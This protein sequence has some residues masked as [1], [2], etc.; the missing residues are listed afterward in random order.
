M[1]VSNK[2]SILEIDWKGIYL[3]CHF[4]KEVWDLE[5]IW[6]FSDSVYRASWRIPLKSELQQYANNYMKRKMLQSQK[7]I[8]ELIAIVLAHSSKISVQYLEGKSTQEREWST[9]KNKYIKHEIYCCI[10]YPSYDYA[11]LWRH[12]CIQMWNM[13][14]LQYSSRN[15]GECA[16][17]P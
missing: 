2:Q 14:I 6:P 3:I 12:C 15:E 7:M 16:L 10:N 8:D 4:L 9:S 5:A 1:N 11:V 13:M 17:N